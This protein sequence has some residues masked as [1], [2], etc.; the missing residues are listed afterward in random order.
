M[1]IDQLNLSFDGSKQESEKEYLQVLTQQSEHEFE[2][3]L[4]LARNPPQAKPAKK[5][6]NIKFSDLLS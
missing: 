6:K 4:S 1:K 5:R 3:A 2:I